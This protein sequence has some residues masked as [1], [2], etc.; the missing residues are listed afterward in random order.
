MGLVIQL[1]DNYLTFSRY[2]IVVG[3]TS[4]AHKV[5]AGSYVLLLNTMSWWL[6]YTIFPFFYDQNSLAWT[7]AIIIFASWVDFACYAAFDIFYSGAVVFIIFSTRLKLG[8]SARARD[9]SL[10]GIRAL[11]HTLFSIVGIFCYAFIIPEGILVQNIFSCTGIHFFLNS[12]IDPDWFMRRLGV[13]IVKGEG[14][15][16][17]QSMSSAKSASRVALDD[18]ERG[19]RGKHYD[20]NTNISE[21]NSEEEEA[22]EEGSS[23]LLDSTVS[24]KPVAHAQK[25]RT[26]SFSNTNTNTNTNNTSVHIVEEEPDDLR[27]SHSAHILVDNE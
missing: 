6:F 13:S 16:S 20:T 7:N 15:Q 17:I 21:L 18:S 25:Q 5:L 11:F 3:G 27:D 10:L 8:S 9:L 19:S 24:L 26:K 23:E 12:K 1:I 2:D 4:T 14:S 22:T